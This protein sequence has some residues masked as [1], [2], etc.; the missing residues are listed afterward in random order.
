MTDVHIVQTADYLSNGTTLTPVFPAWQS[1]AREGV[2][3][4]ELC[5][6]VWRFAFFTVERVETFYPDPG[7]RG[8]K[9]HVNIPE[10]WS[11]PSDTIDGAA[12]NLTQRNFSKRYNWVGLNYKH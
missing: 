4:I 5:K 12:R 9:Q 8:P 2:Y 3:M 10:H 6:G 7:K 11:A 1:P